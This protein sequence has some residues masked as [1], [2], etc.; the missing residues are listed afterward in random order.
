MSNQNTSVDDAAL[1]AIDSQHERMRKAFH[2][3][4]AAAIANDFYTSDAWVVGPDQGTWKGTEQIHNLY[5]DFVGIYHWETKR[6]RLISTGAGEFLEYL[7]GAIEPVAGGEK[8]TYKI[9]F[10]WTKQNNKWL[11]ATQFFAPGA[12]F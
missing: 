6:E 5:R 12:D 1:D 11:C 3:K 2:E 10:A 7:I 9:L 4:D 8:S